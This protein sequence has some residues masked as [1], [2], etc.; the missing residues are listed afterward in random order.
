MVY[1]EAMPDQPTVCAVM[2]TANRPELARRAVEC[3]RAQIYPNL[4]SQL[5]VWDSGSIL[6]F[7]DGKAAYCDD[8]KRTVGEMRNDANSWACDPSFLPPD[9]FIHWD[10]DDYSHPNRIAEQV[11]LLQSSGAD[12]VGY[13][14]MLFWKEGGDAN[15]TRVP[16]HRAISESGEAPNLP[17]EAWLYS[18][19]DPRYCIGTSLCYWRK[20][21]ER[22]PFQALPKTKGGNAEDNEW[23]KSVKSVGVDSVRDTQTEWVT[24]IGKPGKKEL[25]S[26]S[27][28]VPRMVARIHNSNTSDYAS[29]VGK[30]HNWRR[31]PE[32]DSYCESV[33]G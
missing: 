6:A 8:R 18:N 29:V 17:G 3:F 16:Q 2:L 12:A 15:C 24:P 5:L 14:E 33:M 10:D 26:K 21:W 23:L 31:V 4:R 19:P 11:A 13:R 7:A 1:G 32:W 20:T 28:T 27:L 25:V 9:I 30:S 22:V